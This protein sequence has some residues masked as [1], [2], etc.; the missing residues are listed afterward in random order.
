MLQLADMLIVA[1]ID[2]SCRQFVV[3]MH[4]YML[5]LSRFKSSRFVS[6]FMKHF[7][8]QP[9]WFVVIKLEVNVKVHPVTKQL[10]GRGL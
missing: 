5:R 8:L 7:F 3:E 1:D 10:K 6:L 2:V 9:T 4:M